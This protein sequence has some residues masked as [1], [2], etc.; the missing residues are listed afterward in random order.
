MGEISP[1]DPSLYPLLNGSVKF[2]SNDKSSQQFLVVLIRGRGGV[3]VFSG[4][5]MRKIY[6]LSVPN[7]I[8]ISYYYL[9]DDYMQ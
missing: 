6:L 4:I 8:L 9:I 1:I 7:I 2:I 5:F 3:L